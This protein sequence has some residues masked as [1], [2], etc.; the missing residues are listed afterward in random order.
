M[1]VIMKTTVKPKVDLSAK[2]KKAMEFTTILSLLFC[3]ILFQAFKKF[4]PETI[5]TKIELPVIQATDIP[6]TI[7]DN[8]PKPPQRPA[9]PIESE[10][11]EIPPDQTIKDTELDFEEVPQLPLLQ[12]DDDIIKFVPYDSMPKPIGG[13]SAI[14][15]YLEYPEIPRKAGVEGDVVIYAK[16]SIYGT[17]VDTKIIKPLGNSGCN[18]A[19]IKAIKSV[20]WI[21][22]KQRDKAVEV[23]VSVPVKFRLR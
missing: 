16:I 10:S 15:R 11:E 13:Y 7:Q 2:Y 21:P 8:L 14:H 18:E 12:D 23:W 9:I 4:D 6:Q 20:K 5:H 17:V 19:A 22:A 3:I 1:E